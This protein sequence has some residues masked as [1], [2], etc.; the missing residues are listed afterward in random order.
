LGREAEQHVHVI[1]SASGG[2]EH[3]VCIVGLTAEDRCELVVEGRREERPSVKGCPD[4]VNEDEC[5]RA[6]R[7]TLF[8][9]GARAGLPGI[10]AQRFER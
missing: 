7:H 4:D 6:S 9:D 2:E 8:I 5:G 10:S 1:R 3:A